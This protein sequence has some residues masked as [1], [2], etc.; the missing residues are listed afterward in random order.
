MLV[1]G[2]FG[3]CGKLFSVFARNLELPFIRMQ[4]DRKRF[5]VKRNGDRLIGQGFEGFQKN[6]TIH[7]HFGPTITLNAQPRSHGGVKVRGANGKVLGIHI[8]QIVAQNG[9]NV[10]GL[11]YALNRLQLTEEG[12]RRNDEFHK[13]MLIL[14]EQ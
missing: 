13:A 11:D 10:V 6:A 1:T 4:F 2:H 12:R 5:K 3:Q 14:I 9:K 7:G 8:E